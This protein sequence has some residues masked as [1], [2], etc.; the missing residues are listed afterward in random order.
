MKDKIIKSYQAKIKDCDQSIERLNKFINES[1]RD[2]PTMDTE[3][4]L[5]ERINVRRDRQLYVQFVKDIE[6][7]VEQKEKVI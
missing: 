7:I 6:D 4:L 5:E 1:R 3:D 2:N